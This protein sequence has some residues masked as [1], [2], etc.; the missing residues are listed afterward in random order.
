IDRAALPAPEWTSLA[1]GA[2]Y[3]EPRNADEE[4]LLALWSELLDAGAVERAGAAAD[5]FALGGHSLLATQL[6]SRVRDAFGIELPVRSVFE[7]PTVADFAARLAEQRRRGAGGSPVPPLPPI[8]P[9]L[10]AERLAPLALS[11]AQERLWLLDQLQPGNVAYNIPI[12]VRLRGPLDPR[13]FA[14][15]L[16]AVAARHES[17]R[18]TFHA[19]DGRPFQRIAPAL[20][21]ALPVVDLRGAGSAGGAGSTEGASRTEGVG[22]F[23]EAT[24]GR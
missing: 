4:V 12:A 18:T 5:F 9:L 22:G 17:L 24:N 23:E 10:E 14:R 1:A 13:R 8:V 16:D 19:V 7:C 15:C 21:L 3:L 2:P 11:F 6:L 20:A